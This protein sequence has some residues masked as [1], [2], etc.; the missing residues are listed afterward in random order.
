MTSSRL[1][2]KVLMDVAGMPLVG[3]TLRRLGAAQRVDEVVLATTDGATDDPLVAFAESEGVRCHRGSEHD[4]L[5]RVRDAAAAAQADVV[6]RITGDCPLLEPGVVDDVV[7]ALTADPSACDYASNVMRRTY[8]K[9]LDAEALWMDTLLRIDRLAT[10]GIAREHV[11]W[12]A[13]AER[14][15]LFLLRSVEFGEDHSDRNWSVDT[16]EDLARVRTLATP[17]AAGEALPQWT[18]LLAHDRA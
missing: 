9:G 10:S 15:E 1:P 4:V 16:E 3:H 5:R 17:L 2:G 12:L 14:P 6:V 18:E 13:Y 7:N 8:P 11:T